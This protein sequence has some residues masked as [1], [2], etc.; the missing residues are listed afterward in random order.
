MKTAV[1]Y[2][3][4][5]G[6][7]KYA[8]QRI[9]EGLGADRIALERVRKYPDRGLRK[10]FWG[11]KSAVMGETPELEPCGF[12]ADRYDR[13]ILGFPVWAGNIAPPLRTFVLERAGELK[14][15]RV[16]AFACQSGSGAR[17]AFDR[18]CGCLGIGALCA[19]LVLIDPK[20]RPDG[21]NRGKIAEFCRVC[22]GDGNARDVPATAGK[23]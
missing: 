15:K 11:G 3:S 9:A 13:G 23:G 16:A 2:Y 6:N 22:G 10:F 14:E 19:E 8:A 1:V 18:L 7:T 21:A 12:E 17:K 5:G 4:M 20:D